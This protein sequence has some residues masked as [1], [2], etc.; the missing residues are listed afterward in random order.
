[1]IIRRDQRDALAYGTYLSFENRA[2][3][4]LEEHFPDDC[5]LLR[6]NGTRLRLREAVQV[7][8]RYGFQSHREVI[9]FAYLWFL[10]GRNFDVSP[11]YGWLRN[12]LRRSAIPAEARMA[13]AF[14]ALASHIELNSGKSTR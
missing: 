1:M 5:A 3:A 2:V 4:W 14:E 13:Q 12:M 7:A 11:E 8:G 6:P 9:R 10:L